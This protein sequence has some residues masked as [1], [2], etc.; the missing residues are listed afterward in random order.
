MQT[1][2]MIC[3]AEEQALREN[4]TK[5]KDDKTL[6]NPL[7]RICGANVKNYRSVNIR[8]DMTQLQNCS[9]GNCVRSITLKEKRSG[10]S[11]A[12]KELWKMMMLN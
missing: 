10:T 3:A 8:E 6:E 1:E 2:A 9:I 12:V 4:H 11:I 7:Y 5:N